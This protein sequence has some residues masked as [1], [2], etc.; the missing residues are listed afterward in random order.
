MLT[1][2]L[3]Q[4]A[5]ALGGEVSGDQV[6]APGPGHSSVDRSLSIKLD[7]SAP[8][9][10]V[11]NSFAG[12]DPIAC[13]DYV[14]GKL[15]LEGFRPTNGSRRQR[16]SITEI[17]NLLA[18]AMSSAATVES[19]S[20]LGPIVETY[21]YTDKNSALLYEVT[22][23]DPKDFRQRRPNGNGGWIDNLKGVQRVLYRLPE[24]L[25]YP[26]ASVFHTEGE[27]DANRIAALGHCATTVASGS[28]KGVDVGALRDRDIFIVRDMDQAG[29]RK[30][31]N[32]AQTLHGVAKSIRIVELPGLDGNEHNK[33]VSDWLD[34]D[35]RN[36]EKFVDICFAAPLWDP[37]TAPPPPTESTNTANKA[38]RLSYFNECDK[39]VTKPWIMKGLFARGETSSWIAPP[40]AGKSALITAAAV[41]TTAGQDWRSFRC[42]E[43]CGALYLAFERGDL[44]R[45][46]LAAYAKQGFSNLPIAIADQQIDLMHPSCIAIIVAAIREAEEHMKVPVGLII[47]DTYAKGIAI[48]GGDEDKAK[49]Q[50]R[51][52]AHL[53]KVQEMTKA[54]IAIIGHTG[55]DETRGGRGSNAHQADV[56]VQ[57]QISG[58]EAVKTAK[59]IKG[60]DQAT[61]VLL[62]F[63]MR[64]DVMGTDED[65]DEITVGVV[66]DEE[67]RTAPRSAW[68]KSLSQLLD[69]ITTASIDSGF[70]HRIINGPMVRAVLLERVRAVYRRNYIVA[71][72][73]E[74]RD[75]AVNKA[76]SRALKTARD[77]RLIGGTYEG[78]KQVVWI[79]K[80]AT[81]P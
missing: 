30:A 8:D 7:P 54:H 18:G 14:R 74:S 5:K 45:R 11:V 27:K 10:F 36:A 60:N 50:S 77:A 61:G 40:G 57:V 19:K 21:P 4:I 31:Y 17:N 15:G 72:D 46:R 51:C 16:A 58:D 22:R 41:Y 48:G 64:S 71:P 42:K 47:I 20:A 79:A 59:V 35:P 37:S 6:R 9:G 3:Q 49:D 53:R 29:A 80:E 2:S 44:A 26:D 70:D 69:A 76:F 78:G 56:D 63:T 32:A 12:D 52:L 43:R 25:A 23:H 1:L 34:K 38:L 67:V 13:K 33:D 65:G 66:S 55:K 24:L 68:P 81:T 39:T 75:E 62:Q 28:W 73:S